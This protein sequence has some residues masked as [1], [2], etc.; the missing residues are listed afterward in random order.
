MIPGRRLIRMGRT[1]DALLLDDREN[2]WT[3]DSRRRS[4]AVPHSTDQNALAVRQHAK[5]SSPDRTSLPKPV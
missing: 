5:V 1:V 4:I 2:A 3:G